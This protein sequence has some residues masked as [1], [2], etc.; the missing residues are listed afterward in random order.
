MREWINLVREFLRA[1]RQRAVLLA[2][3]ALIQTALASG[4]A[5]GSRR[6][7]AA[8]APVADGGRLLPDGSTS[9]ACNEAQTAGAPLGCEYLIAPVHSSDGEHC[10]AV[11][12]SNPNS[13][14]V[15]LSVERAGKVVELSA[16]ARLISK[17]GVD[18]GWIPLEADSLP[19]GASAVVA[20]ADGRADF[21]GRGKCPFV[22]LADS[23]SFVEDLPAQAFRLLSTA[24]VLAVQYYAYG[25][26]QGG[27]LTATS[28]LRSTSAWATD[29]V[30]VGVYAPGRPDEQLYEGNSYKL[31]AKAFTLIVAS[32]RTDVSLVRNDGVVTRTLQAG[33]AQRFSR[34]DLFIGSAIKSTRPVAVLVG[35]AE[36]FM[37]YNVPSADL[38]LSQVPPLRAWRS[39]YAVTSFPARKTGLDDAPL[40]RIVAASAGT[41]LE[42][43]PVRPP[44]APTEV[45]AGELAVFRSA[46]PFV[47]RSQDDEHP[48]YV[49]VAM[50][51]GM[52]LCDKFSEDGGVPSPSDTV[53]RN[54]PGDPELVSV[55]PAS[56]YAR[57]FSFVTSHDFADTY[58]VLVR[59]RSE[60][61]EFADVWLDCAGV[62]EGWKP[63]GAGSI[64]ETAM[65]PLSRGEFEPQKYPGGSCQLGAHQMS[66]DAAF[67]G[68]L[69]AWSHRIESLA[70]CDAGPCD[71]GSARSYGFALYGLDSRAVKPR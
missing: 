58:L 56:E 51:G 71:D 29:H 62:V 24:P 38:I 55:T 36:S 40:L 5:C 20:L 32:E 10:T 45:G 6:E 14:P 8:A 7:T 21:L 66:S 53:Y 34:D 46:V 60:G 43:D 26:P 57:E 2:G 49:S 22:P 12:V 44:E 9:S 63:I 18:P 25:V 42:Y 19:A 30:D 52:P 1:M 41:R 59:K 3:A 39:E 15:R 48:F 27:W 35:A 16:S 4:V 54:C 37:P 68:Y 17:Y 13:E 23:S 31:E 11:L 61:G 50:T 28:A 70:D 64:Y 33:E 69:W 47:V 67:T 65:L